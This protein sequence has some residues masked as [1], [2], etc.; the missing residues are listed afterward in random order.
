MPSVPFLLSLCDPGHRFARFDAVME[1]AQK[2]FFEG[3]Q[4]KKR[5]LISLS[6]A[7]DD[8]ESIDN[9]TPAMCLL[10]GT[11]LRAGEK[12]PK[13]GMGACHR[14]IGLRHQEASRDDPVFAPRWGQGS[15]E[16]A[17]VLH[18]CC[19]AG[20]KTGVGIFLLLNRTSVLLVRKSWSCYWPSIY[21]D[22]FGEEDVNMRRGMPLVLSPSRA[23]ALWSLYESG[24][25]ADAVTQKRMSSDRVLRRHWY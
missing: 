21:V 14:H 18:R 7:I 12:F 22:E 15:E 19:P 5:K 10:C 24:G 25:V 17:S 20:G 9:E 8:L 13:H 11:F 2:W 23:A 16:I 4:A 6:G 3:T 1:E